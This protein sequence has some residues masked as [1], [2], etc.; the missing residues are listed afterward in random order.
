MTIALAVLFFLFSVFF[1]C[2]G[3][4]L[5]T[6]TQRILEHS[7]DASS[8]LVQS[9]IDNHIFIS[10]DVASLLKSVFFIL[11]EICLIFLAGQSGW[12]TMVTLLLVLLLFAA[13]L[14][15]ESLFLLVASANGFWKRNKK[16]SALPFIRTM[17]A[18]GRSLSRLMPPTIRNFKAET[19]VAGISKHNNADRKELMLKGILQFGK[20]TVRDI[21]TSRVDVVDLDIKTPFSQ[22][23]RIIADDNYSRIPVFSGSR[24][25]V[26]GILYIKDLLPYLDKPDSFR[27]SFLIRPNLCVPE[28]KKIDNLLRE[29]QERKIHIAVVVDEYGGVSGVVTLED[30][31]EEIVGEIND[32]YDDENNPYISLGN[33]SYIF[34]AK[35]SLQ[36][37]C[38]LFDLDTAFFDDVDGDSD[39]LAG[40]LLDLIGDFP[41]KHQKVSY[42][43]FNFEILDVDE[44]HISKVKVSLKPHTEA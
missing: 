3:L 15:T 44:R 8:P 27:W 17:T 34:D 25:N 13:L 4:V 42:R 6:K 41:Q 21:M 5:S 35:T 28:T 14:L 32:E 24:D 9:F 31:I 7:V 30:I 38:K 39:T 22:V 23:V 10:N 36:D 19:R 43:Q 37:F 33:N 16:L 29:F 1:S 2:V 18:L 40:L 26:V 12:G 20:E 11:A